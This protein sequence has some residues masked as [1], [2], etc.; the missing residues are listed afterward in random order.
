M[1]YLL[2][3]TTEED[4]RKAND[5]YLVHF[6]C[7]AAGHPPATRIGYQRT[8]C[9]CGAWV[10]PITWPA[11]DGEVSRVTVDALNT[12]LGEYKKRCIHLGL[13]L[14]RA[15]ESLQENGAP[16]LAA[17]LTEVLAGRYV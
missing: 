1:I 17:D 9:L 16:G 5:A 6:I 12:E 8:E 7:G 3:D 15:I 13:A 2:R 11:D 14:E 10:R 4:L